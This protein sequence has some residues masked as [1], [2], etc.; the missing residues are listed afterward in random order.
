MYIKEINRYVFVEEEVDFVCAGTL[1]STSSVLT[2]A[3]CIID[4]LS[5]Q[6]NSSKYTILLKPNDQLI[7]YYVYLGVHDRSNV[8]DDYEN[9]IQ[10]DK[11]IMVRFF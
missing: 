10:V 6:V 8:D 7:K 4:I 11:V 2:A 9:I 1:I 5:V 3:S